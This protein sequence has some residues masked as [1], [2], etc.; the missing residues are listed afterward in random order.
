M[1]LYLGVDLGTASV[2]VLVFDAAARRVIS[3]GQAI[4]PLLSMPRPGAAEQ[5]PADWWEAFCTAMD[6]ALEQE[7]VDRNAIAALGVSGQQHGMVA[8]D[9]DNQVLRP[10]KLWCDLEA[11]AEAEQLSSRLPYPVA[12]GFTAPKVLWFFQHEPELAARMKRLAL[13]HDWLNLQLTGT[14]A[15][16]HGDASGTG[17]YDPIAGTYL[18]EV[19]A[20]IHPQLPEALAPLLGPEEQLG[21]LLPQHAERFGLPADLPVSVGS[22][23]NM[24]SALGAGATEA[25]T[26]VV[27]LGTSGTIFGP[28]TEAVIDPS[29]DVAPFRSALGG[30]LPLLC[31]QNCASVVEEARGASG[32]SHEE[33]SDAAAALPLSA[34]D[35]LFLPYLSGERSPNWPHAC[36]VLFGLRPQSLQPERLYRAALEGASLALAQGM[37]RLVALGM[38]LRTLRLVGGGAKNALWARILCDLFGRPLEIVEEPETAALG[39][40][41]QACWM[42]SGEHPRNL[43]PDSDG[44]TLRPDF[45]QEE[46]YKALAA[47]FQALGQQLFASP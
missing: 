12:A 22:G 1:S 8:L 27:S 2:K 6:Q 31:T 38:P 43:A 44:L 28:T 11:S 26:W 47:R 36:G 3:R 14:F 40:A 13:P 30:G 39:A 24:M 34:D 33:L 41:M 23:D 17:L 15:T 5:N 45:N 10:A 37:D 25:G 4:L 32:Q 35:P 7:G 42:H 20:T 18:T 29:G 16:D 19:A 9:E 21:T 46:R